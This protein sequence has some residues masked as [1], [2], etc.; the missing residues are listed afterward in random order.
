M[1]LKSFSII[2][3]SNVRRGM[4]PANISGRPL[5]ESAQVVP[6][7][8]RL[9][10]L[11]SA[12]DSVREES[13]ACIV[14]SI[15]NIVSNASGSSV[16]AGARVSKFMTDFFQKIFAYCV[17]RPDIQVFVLPPMYRTT[18]IWYREGMAEILL[19][20][21]HLATTLK[22][23][24]YNFHLMSSF[25]RPSLEPDGVHLT[26]YSGME[27]VLHLFNEAERIM[28]SL[29]SSPESK[30]SV[31]DEEVRLIKDRVLALEQDH[32]RLNDKSE[33]QYAIDQELSDFQQNIRDEVFFMISGL[34]RLPRLDPREW[35][36]RA[37]ADVNRVISIL[38]FTHTA[39]YVYNSSGR[40]KNSL[41]LYK[42]RCDSVEIS[43]S[44]RDKFA[45]F[46]AR[47]ENTKPAEL[48]S[49][50]IRNCVTTATL[51]RIA[52]M[53]LLGKRYVASN[54]GARSQVIGFEPRPLL[55]LTPP[56]DSQDKRVMTFNFIEAVTKLPTAFTPDEVADLLRRISPRLHTNLRPLFIVISDD[57]LSKKSVQKESGSVSSPIASPDA[58]GHSGSGSGSKS[59][60]GRG[61]SSKRGPP[62]PA[63]GPSAKK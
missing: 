10:T 25:D 11:S 6:A 44:I 55:K 63:S 57:M 38:G 30:L 39:R 17:L 60:Q 62:T 5:W 43:R 7:G 23:R 13:D 36:Q 20:F 41:V 24:P 33:R 54:D 2:G 51:G 3:D 12:L 21:S 27:F 34:N 59:S 45:S 52:I 46:F 18:P 22:P 9:S 56:P 1:M 61:R 16:S 28:T 26:P 40:G 58:S 31:V 42:V 32:R 19:K 53:Q 50:S 29:A 35:Q 47:G 8:G 15:S 4:S 49:V 14:A 48:S 37:Q